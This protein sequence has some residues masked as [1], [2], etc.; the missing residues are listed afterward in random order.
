MLFRSFNTNQVLLLLLSICGLL[1]AFIFWDYITFQKVLLYTDIGSD[2][3]NIFYPF[4][5]HLADLWREQG[6]T[7]FYTLQYAMGQ[8]V[9]I[10]YFKFFQILNIL[11]GKE[12]IPYVLT[13]AEIFKVLGSTVIMFFFFKLQ[14]L[15]KSVSFIGALLYGFSGYLIIGVSGWYHHSA[16]AFWVAVFLLISEKFKQNRAIWLLAIP[17][18]LYPHI[19]FLLTI[20]LTAFLFFYLLF[21]SLEDND[22]PIEIVKT[23]GFAALSIIAGALLGH[24]KINSQ[25][26]SLFKSGRVEAIEAS[27]QGNFLK[28]T[29]ITKICSEN[30]ISSIIYRLFSNNMVGTAN[31]FHGWQ[32]YL[33]APILYIGLLSL[34]VLPFVFVK[35]NNKLKLIYGITLAACVIMLIFPWFR[36]A[37]WGFK[38]DYFRSFGFFISVVVLLLAMRGLN[39]MF[40]HEGKLIP[41]I[42]SC[43]IILLVLFNTPKIDIEKID[44]TTRLWLF[45]FTF[46]YG[47]FSIFYTK[48]QY[49]AEW[50]WFLIAIVCFEVGVNAKATVN[51]R[52][53]LTSEDIING[54]LYGDETEGILAKIKEEDKGFFR[55]AKY[56]PSGPAIHMSMNDAIVQNF[57]GII[58]YNSVHNKNYLTFLRKLG[59]LD[60]NNPNDLKWAYKILNRPFL[61][62]FVGAKYFLSKGNLSLDNVS[63]KHIMTEKDIQVHKSNIALPIVIGYDQ[64]ILEDDFM[65][66]SNIKKDY[67]LFKAIVLSSEQ[68]EKYPFLKQ[69]NLADTLKVLTSNHFVTA[70]NERIQLAKSNLSVTNNSVEGSIE[71]TKPCLIHIAIPDTGKLTIDNKP[72]FMDLNPLGFGIAELNSTGKQSIKLE[73]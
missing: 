17:I 33:E 38:V 52:V 9:E 70:H 61:A 68:T 30:E 8:K 32:N 31:D 73:L 65:K 7:T 37:Y 54:K 19:N 26:N 28:N 56:Y 58:G 42:I 29:P 24:N 35:V 53:T 50:K 12:N 18:F 43:V 72:L 67:V 64:Y 57:Y 5:A 23:Y 36:Y 6:G 59:C 21:R 47:I 40:K 45:I 2:S 46:A 25:I 3:V 62:S 27:A 14:K 71:T 16:E 15:N 48:S 44:L 10:S 69:F 49:K 55:V 4:W 51:E 39:N 34:L 60:P 11:A 1:S 20:Q 63:F 22:K 41:L 66:L 13:F